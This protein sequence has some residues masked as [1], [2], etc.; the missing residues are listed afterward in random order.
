MILYFIKSMIC[1]TILLIVFHQWIERE[2]NLVF[3]RYYLLGSICFGLLIPLVALPQFEEKILISNIQMTNEIIVTSSNSIVA[4]LPEASF[5]FWTIILWIYSIIT[6][7][8]IFRFIKSLNALFKQIK[9]AQKKPYQQ[10]KLVLIESQTSPYTF[11]KYIFLNKKAY[12]NGE[13]EKELLVH[14]LAH[15]KAYHTLDILFVEVFSIF[16]WFNPVLF[17][18]KKA[19]KLN[20]EYLADEAVNQRFQ[21]ITRYQQLLLNKTFLK[22]PTVLVNTFGYFSTKKRFLMMLQNKSNKRS[23]LKKMALVPVFLIL[24]FLFSSKFGTEII[25]QK[26]QESTSTTKENS[27]PEKL[28]LSPLDSLRAVKRKHYKGATFTVK[29]E[30]GKMIKKKFDE[31]SL[32]EIDGFPSPPPLPTAKKISQQQLDDWSNPK[33]YGVW[34]DDKRIK[35]SD[36]KNY[37]PSDFAYYMSSRLMKNAV[38]YGQYTYN[39]SLSTPAYFEAWK[40]EMYD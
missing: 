38:H 37:K 15:A 6:F 33:E 3:N 29:D 20:H 10:T 22:P 2:K 5:S 19:I 32:E 23:L 21:N 27:H 30:N 11:L 13:I 39:L 24:I 25:G 17:F 9:I 14:E 36:L 16:F 31:L 35:N 7:L 1:L 28:S 8:L 4:T 18:Y 40:S 34:I 12:E 26:N